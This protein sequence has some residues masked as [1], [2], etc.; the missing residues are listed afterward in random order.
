[1]PTPIPTGALTVTLTEA[2]ADLTNAY[3]VAGR[4][5]HTT[6]LFTHYVTQ[7]AEF[8]AAD[9]ITDIDQVTSA[10]L[11]RFLAAEKKRG[12]TAASVSVILRTIR[13]YFQWAVEQNLIAANPAR[14][15]TAPRVVIDSSMT[16]RSRR[17]S[18]ASA[19][20]RSKISGTRRCSGSWPRACAEVN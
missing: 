8:L 2:L 18:R 9:G 16:T 6:S 7:M 12:L 17:C 15:V 3:L 1:L 4:S 11:T 19:R 13:R 20:P 10:H 14:A 5:H